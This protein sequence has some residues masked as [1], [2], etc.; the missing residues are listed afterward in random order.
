[1]H[2]TTLE[3]M[4]GPRD[5]IWKCNLV[6][7]WG[8]SV[9]EVYMHEDHTTGYVPYETQLDILEASFMCYNVLQWTNA[10]IHSSEDLSV[11]SISSLHDRGH[12]FFR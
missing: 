3:K 9:M 5:H 11:F 1:M 12:L 7:V 8:Q 4:K 10:Q 6:A 2:A